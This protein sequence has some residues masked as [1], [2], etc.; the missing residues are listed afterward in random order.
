VSSNNG[1]APPIPILEPAPRYTVNVERSDRG[2]PD[3]HFHA[4]G[5]GVWVARMVNRLGERALLCSP[6]A[7]ESGHMLGA[8][9]RAEGIEMRAVEC[10]GENGGYIHDRRDGERNVMVDV[11]SPVLNRHDA[12]NLYDVMLIEG[13]EAGVAVI[14]GDA[15][16]GIGEASFFGR[17]ALDLGNNGV[18]VAADLSGEALRAIE[19]G[20]TFLKVS[21][22]D[23]VRDGFLK[24]PDEDELID[25]I[26][27]FAATKSEHVIVSRADSPA[28]T[29]VE[30]QLR[31]LRSPNFK[32]ADH[33]GAGDSMTAALAVG[34][35]RR[36]EV[37]E[38][39]RLGAAAGALNVTR[40]G[41]G[42]A[43][44]NQVE[45]LAHLVQIQDA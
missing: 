12:D 20:L 16:Q 15:R 5:Q 45:R 30:G 13:L 36:L 32:P 23:L 35:A 43:P 17:L 38:I 26:Q 8:L 29:L 9:I 37:D 40:R 3:V 10:K 25:L 2:G 39:L 31:H 27:E 22:D 1:G 14:T 4:G 34:L 24:S 19:G 11:D 7:G 42:N 33:R 6:I 28:L 21:E 41:L 44:G 18:R